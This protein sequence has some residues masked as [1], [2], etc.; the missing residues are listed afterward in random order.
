MAKPTRGGVMRLNEDGSAHVTLYRSYDSHDK[1]EHLS[2]EQHPDG[3]QTGVHY[4][5]HKTGKHSS[6]PREWRSQD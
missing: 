6:D 5:W 1:G 3:S 4:T 2:W